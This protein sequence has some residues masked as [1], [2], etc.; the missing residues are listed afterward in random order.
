MR[1]YW[2]TGEQNEKMIEKPL[3]TPQLTGS[4]QRRLCCAK[5]NGSQNIPASAALPW[6]AEGERRIWRVA[7]GCMADWVGVAELSEVNNFLL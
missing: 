4:I 5:E 6:A 2:A 3:K 7:T 1:A